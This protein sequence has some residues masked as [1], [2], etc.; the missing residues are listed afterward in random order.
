MDREN[1][2]QIEAYRRNE[3]G[4]LENNLIDELMNG[5]LDRR[6]FITRAT[7]FGLSLGTIGLLLGNSARQPRLR[8]RGREGR[9]HA[10]R[11]ALGGG[12]SLEP[13]LLN[14]GGSLAFAG[15][16]AEYLTFTNPQGRVLPW[17]ATSWKP[18]ADAT[19]WTFQ[20]RKGV[21]FHN[22][23]T[24][25]ASGRRREHEAIRERKGLERGPLP[26]LRRRGRFGEGRLHGGLPA[27]V[28][29]RRVPVPRE[30]DDVPG[31]HPARGDRSEARNVGRER[32]DRHRARSSS[33]TTS[34]REAPSS[35]GTTPTGAVAR[36]STA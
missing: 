30:P 22:G 28:A 12:G 15:I 11:R 35:S 32:D 24:M 27:Q 19:V 2:R 29:D 7:M 10:P 6:E 23:K 3:A 1:R 26:V 8:P 13:Y 18:N 33:R 16:P 4:P 9:R 17:L 31:D 34:T 36:R 25:T 21:K 14:E 5:E 20:L